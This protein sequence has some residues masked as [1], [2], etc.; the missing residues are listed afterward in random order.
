M[1]AYRIYGVAV[2]VV[3]GVRVTGCIGFTAHNRLNIPLHE[4]TCR[5]IKVTNED[6]GV[7]VR[8]TD[9]PGAYNSSVD[10]NVTAT[11]VPNATSGK[12]H[13]GLAI[14]R[15]LSPKPQKSPW[16]VQAAIYPGIATRADKAGTND[17]VLLPCGEGS[18]LPG[19]FTAARAVGQRTGFSAAAGGTINRCG[20]AQVAAR[21]TDEAGLVLEAHDAGGHQKQWLLQIVPSQYVRIEIQHFW[22]EVPGAA[23]GLAYSTTVGRCGVGGW[24]AAADMYKSWAVTQY[25]AATRLT[26]R[27]DVPPILL[28]GAPGLIL[29][30]QNGSG[31]CG[32]AALGPN[33][34]KL[35]DYVAAY[36]SRLQTPRAL[37]V[38]YGW[39]NRGTWAGIQYFPAV[40][41]NAAWAQ[42]NNALAAAGDGS[43]FLVSGSWWVVKREESGG[44]P[45]FDDSAVLHDPTMT[46]MLVKTQ[47]PQNGTTLWEDDQY[48]MT[49]AKQP[50]RGLS[51]MLCHGH[52]DTNA[53]MVDTFR[54]IR[55]L[56]VTVASFDQDI[57]GDQFEPCYDPNHSHTPGFGTYMLEGFR[58]Y[59]RSI[60]AE[61]R[62]AGERMGLSSEQ[63][64]ELAIPQMSTFW[65][66]QFAQIDYP[67]A[68]FEG[69]GLFSY[70]YHE[71]VNG[72][73]FVP[74]IVTL[75]ADLGVSSSL[76]SIMSTPH[77]FVPAMAAAMVQ[78]QGANNLRP[79]PLLR[80]KA[81]AD[82][83]VR[84]LALVPFT[85]DVP[86]EATDSWHAAVSEAFFSYGGVPPRF[87]D[88]LVLG[89][90][91]H[92]L[93]LDCAELSVFYTVG[94]RTHPVKKPITIPA[95]VTGS[96]RS[97]HTLQ[98]IPSVGSVFANVANTTQ[99]VQ[100]GLGGSAA[101]A[102]SLTL[103][104]AHRNTL[105]KWS[106]G[107]IPD[108][109]NVSLKSFQVVFLEA[110]FASIL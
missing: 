31:Y 85:Q 30:I 57:S 16:A 77:R 97:P 63:T 24:R 47:R 51:V 19:P 70:L 54:Q 10:L 65:S 84:G 39:E 79:H 86:L 94:N 90:T 33:L 71:Y 106:S 5:S 22:P 98:K 1:H 14:E 50:W 44:G 60:N 9:H 104:D 68:G 89:E 32:A 92:P 11:V 13:F 15:S 66:R 27:D 56:G 93:E 91:L 55:S 73:L 110:S 46:A 100:V 62:A 102:E 42:A 99:V 81:M 53:T 41:S 72:P 34:E 101:G 36:K 35:P 103:F 25:W 38:P 109:V 48:N 58:E 21:V 43:M 49:I 45:A 59:T 12:V 7:V 28:S 37:F 96:F 52:P 87:A 3:S 18:V 4:R 95:V 78:G 80:V 26:E 29:G 67:T 83:L 88:H 107:D 23:V 76:T 20:A 108:R 64:A 82:A 17:G 75:F 61:T 74:T 105:Q 40:P 2:R 6:G 69:V 8:F